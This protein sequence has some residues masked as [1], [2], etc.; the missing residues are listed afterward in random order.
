MKGSNTC[1]RFLEITYQSC[2]YRLNEPK[3]AGG[4]VVPI[5]AT[6]AR[7]ICDTFNAITVML[8]HWPYN[9]CT[10]VSATVSHNDSD[11]GTIE[12]DAYVVHSACTSSRNTKYQQWRISGVDVVP[13][14]SNG[15]CSALVA[16]ALS[17]G[18]ALHDIYENRCSK[19]SF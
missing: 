4:H 2:S 18:Q 5:R 6:S 17:P 11:I 3:A 12:V 8:Y 15:N 1:S 9:N 13:T 14:A 19:I 16:P 10:F 7:A